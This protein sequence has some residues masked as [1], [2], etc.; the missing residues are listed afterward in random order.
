MR[1]NWDIYGSG[2]STGRV[3]AKHDLAICS[4]Y[5][6]S[7]KA[8]DAGPYGT[9]VVGPWD[10]GYVDGYHVAVAEWLK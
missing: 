5:A 8:L 9:P 3:S 2:W 6:I 10:R 4:M 1:T 7:K